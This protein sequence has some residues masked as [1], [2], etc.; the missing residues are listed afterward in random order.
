[1]EAPNDIEL[2]GFSEAFATEVVRM[3]RRSFQRAMGLEEH[4][5]YEEFR[6]QVGYFASLSEADMCIVIR[7]TTSK[8]VGFMVLE[9][10]YEITQLYIDVDEQGKGYGSF[11]LNEAKKKSPGTLELYTFQKNTG[12]QSFYLRHGFVEI[13]RGSAQLENNP[14]ASDINELADIRYR[15]VAG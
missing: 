2:L 1:M 7:P 14:W 4:N 13:E 3:W 11:L 12:A 9:N 8:V 5:R 6:G 15:W 10:D